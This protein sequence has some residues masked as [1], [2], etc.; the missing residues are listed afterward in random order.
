MAPIRTLYSESTDAKN[1][2]GCG[3]KLDSREPLAEVR[4]DVITKELEKKNDKILHLQ[5][6][7]NQYINDK[8]QNDLIKKQLKEE[9]K[10]LKSKN[11]NLTE[12][13]AK[14]KSLKEE[15]SLTQKYSSK[16]DSEIIFLKAELVNIKIELDSKVSELERLKSEDILISVVGGDSETSKNL[17]QYFARRK[18]MNEVEKISTDIPTHTNDKIVLILE[19]SK[20]DTKVTSKVSDETII[21]ENNKDNILQPINAGNQFQEIKNMTLIRSHNITIGKSKELSIIALGASMA[22]FSPNP[23]FLF[24][25]LEA[26]FYLQYD[27]LRVMDSQSAMQK[28]SKIPPMKLFLMD[29]DEAN[30]H[31]ASRCQSHPASPTWPFRMIVTGKS[32]SG[33]TN[34]LTNLFLGDKAEYIYKG[35]KGGRR[36]ISCDDLIVCGYHP[37]EPKWAFVRYMYGIISKDPKVPY[38]ENIRFSYISSEKIPSV[39]AFSSEQSTAIVFEDLCLTSEHIQNRIGQFFGNG[40]Y[41]DVSKI[42]RRYTDDVKNASMVINSYLRKGKFI[43]FDLDRP[44]DDLL[45]IWLRFDTLLDL[46]KEI[47]LWQKHKIKNILPTS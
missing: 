1:F 2:Q 5:K 22:N 7:L 6:K 43:V 15:L 25:E 37:D 18:I 14:I 46:Q 47:E 16:K 29:M 21:N 36:Y 28:N 39:K 45:A 27:H 23:A 17:S 10:E 3:Y 42:I 35:K 13:K 12:Y 34:I 41:E 8:N 11:T 44:E 20:I 19:S 30:K 32:G 31:V 33:K 38:Y 40:S 26:R 9:I 24:F 4:S